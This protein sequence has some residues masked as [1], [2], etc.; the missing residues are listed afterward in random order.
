[1]NGL[2]KALRRIRRGSLWLIVLLIVLATWYVSHGVSNR[3]I[4]ETLLAESA[5]IQDKVDARADELGA[6]LEAMDRK[7]DA[8]D[9]KLDALDDKLDRLL[10]L[11]QPPL[12]DGLQKVD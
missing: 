9:R 1:M 12:P 8:A 2:E 6:K 3:T 5:R 11:A 7:L 10:R 4:L